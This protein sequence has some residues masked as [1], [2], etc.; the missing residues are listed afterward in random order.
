MRATPTQTDGAALADFLILGENTS[1][2]PTALAAESLTKKSFVVT[3]SSSSSTQGSVYWIRGDAEAT[4]TLD[5]E[6]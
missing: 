1:F 4:Y 6:L 3:A 5:A 2:A